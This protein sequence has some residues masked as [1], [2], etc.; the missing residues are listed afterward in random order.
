M[1]RRDAALEPIYAATGVTAFDDWEVFPGHLDGA[2]VCTA[3]MRGPE[4]HFAFAPGW[5]PKGSL[6]GRIR[7]FLEPLL[8]RHGYL[9][10]RLALTRMEKDRFVRRMGFQPTWT[11][12]QF[13]YYLMG[14][15][16]FT[17]T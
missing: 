8:E 9:T 2:H 12:G 10:T 7:N 16:P 4:I 13:Q 5:R 17:R 15:L 14:S 11:D 3:I 6:R 1:P